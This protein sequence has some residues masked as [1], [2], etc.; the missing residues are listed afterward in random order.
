[1]P[2]SNNV[3]IRDVAREAGVSP[4]TVSRALSGKATYGDDTRER[5]FAT[6]QRLGYRAPPA[7]FAR[8]PR[9]IALLV[10]TLSN[11][12]FG[13]LA[14][15]ALAAARSLDYHLL[16]VITDGNPDRQREEISALRARA[17]DG[18]LFTTADAQDEQFAALARSG[19]P[20][21]LL[22]HEVLGIDVCCVINDDFRGAL[23]A[24]QHL[25]DFGHRRIAAV[26]DPSD[27]LGA[28]ERVRGY[29]TA[30]ERAGLA[31]LVRVVNVE[32]AQV[33]P[34]RAAALGLLADRT[35]TAILAHNDLVAIGVLQACRE[36]GLGVPSDVSVVGYDGTILARVTQ[37]PLT[38]VAQPTREI[39][40]V[41]IELVHQLLSTT[42][43]TA[44]RVVLQPT[45]VHG[46]TT[47]PPG[48]A[49][50]LR[51]LKD[52]EVLPS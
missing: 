47:G 35:T 25:L 4:S 17:I 42:V 27:F 36:L 6:A 21:A 24:T 38:T 30:M 13:E 49:G 8:A 43:A 10:P 11:P 9:A 37:P 46:R 28:P 31:D 39:G 15:G 51:G 19:V 2:R 22:T 14:E 1:V 12:F 16:L 5:V 34:G 52:R 20:L 41:G 18:F 32:R 50:G 23:E 7:G 33:E 44:R 3:S 29:R 40:A 48:P 26:I 45:L